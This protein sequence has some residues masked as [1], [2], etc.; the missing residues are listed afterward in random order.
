MSLKPDIAIYSPDGTLQ[1]IVEVKAVVDTDPTWAAQY[2]RNLLAH[3]VIPVAPYFLLLT[4]DRAYLW[5]GNTGANNE[6]P[7]AQIAINV[8]LKRFLPKNEGRLI[9]TSLE[10][11]TLT[12]L[13]D[14]ASTSS[15]AFLAGDTKNFLE[16]SGLLDR[17]RTGSL[18]LE[19]SL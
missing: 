18:A 1:V 13:R 15:S 3:E 12:W 2:R 9:E 5:S 16:D 11:A 10:M 4:A 19:F 17:I 6:P 7:K 8:L 14:L